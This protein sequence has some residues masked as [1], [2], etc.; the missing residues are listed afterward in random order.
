MIDPA[1]GPLTAWQSTGLRQVTFRDAGPLVQIKQH[2]DGTHRD[3][4]PTGVVPLGPDERVWAQPHHRK[5][6][7]GPRWI[8]CS[9][10]A[11]PIMTRARRA[12]EVPMWRPTPRSTR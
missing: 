2:Y 7:G 4:N 12:H 10:P 8:M 9:A 3:I 11:S 1:W 5:E 6:L